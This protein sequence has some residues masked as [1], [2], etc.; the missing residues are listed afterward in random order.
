MSNDGWTV[1]TGGNAFPF[2]VLGAWVKIKVQEF[3]PNLPVTDLKTGE[4]KRYPSGGPILMHRIG[5]DVL[6]ASDPAFPAGTGTS[7]YM[8]GAAKPTGSDDKGPYGSRN[9]VI[10]AAIKAATGSNQL[11]PKATLTVQYVGDEP[12][13]PRGMSPTKR[14]QAWYSYSYTAP[15]LGTV[16]P[17]AAPPAA[18]AATTAPAA[19]P[20]QSAGS[21]PTAGAATAALTPQ[22]TM[23]APASAVPNGATAALQSAP[24]SAT[25][26]LT[27]EQEAEA[28]LAAYL[29]EQATV[30]AEP[31]WDE[32][33]RVNPLRAKGLDDATIR[34]ILK[35]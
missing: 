4:A 8:S 27:P 25:D 23:S 14:Y 10:A 33:P 26:T 15:A 28:A 35:I 11:M 30:P 3:E 1:P 17:T 18:T 9:A 19:S 16:G 22:V 29:A 32:D 31:A 20:V 7:V 6:E 12:D 5:G 13:T 34:S 24:T 2:D 21:T